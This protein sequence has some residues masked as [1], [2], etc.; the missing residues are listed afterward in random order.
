MGKRRLSILVVL[1]LG[2]PMVLGVVR[3]G[4]MVSLL[5]LNL[6]LSDLTQAALKN[7]PKLEAARLSVES[8]HS[9]ANSLGAAEFPRLQLSGTYYYNTAIPE[10]S[11]SP[12][13]PPVPF[14]FNNNWSA[15]ASLNFDLWDFRSL[16]NQANSA[17]SAYESQDQSYEAAKRELLL[18]V[19]MAYFQTQINLEQVRLLGDSLQLAQAQYVDIGHQARFGTASRLDALSSHQEVL[20]YQRSFSQAQANLSFALRDLFNLVGVKEPGDFTSPLDVRM[21]GNLPKS[22]A[23]PSVWL[24]MDP[25]GVSLKALREESANPPDDSVPQVKTYTYLVDSE[26]FAADAAAKAASVHVVEVNTG[27]GIGGKGYFVV[28]GEPGAVRTAVS[29]GVKAI[30]EDAVISRMVLPN[31]H[32]HIREAIM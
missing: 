14:G 27:K 26:R 12:L 7:S 6:S 30:G 24:S 21:R 23:G 9:E 22:V 16:H 3:A 18:A 17:Y 31:A 20:N 11:V 28:C 8:A 13:A 10:F 5:T 25:A 29:A 4:E 1:T 32:A 2:F 15:N 19:R